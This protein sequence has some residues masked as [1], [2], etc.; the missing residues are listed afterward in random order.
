MKLDLFV[1]AIFSRLLTAEDNQG[2]IHIKSRTCFLLY[3]GE[4]FIFWSSK[5]EPEIGL[6]SIEAECTAFSQGMRFFFAKYLVLDLGKVTVYDL[7]YTSQ[8]SKG[9]EK[10]LV[11]KT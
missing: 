2:L 10:I 1:D 8:V 6:S 4:V 3:V 11:H 5:L 7:K 9:W